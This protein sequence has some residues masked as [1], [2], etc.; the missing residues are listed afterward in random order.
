MGITDIKIKGEKAEGFVKELQE[1]INQTG[2]NILSKTDL[3]D[4]LLYLFNKY[5]DHNFLDKDSNYEN[6]I[7][8]KITETRLK[9][10]K[11]NIALKYKTHDERREAFLVFLRKIAGGDVKIK[12]HDGQFTFFIDDPAA[13]LELEGELKKNGITLEY[14]ENREWVKLEKTYLLKIFKEYAKCSDAKFMETVKRELEKKELIA[15]GKKIS[16]NVADFIK[17]IAKDVSK[18]G[19]VIIAK[20]F[21][22]I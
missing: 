3:Y 6:V 19:I 8:L 17:E 15:K 14:G 21:F 11:L 13:R 1:K 2:Y 5:N 4:F 9:S 22:G 20:A 16:G 18:A 10:A 7:A 12:E